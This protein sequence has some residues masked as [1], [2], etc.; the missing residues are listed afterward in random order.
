MA[1]VSNEGWKTTPDP[2]GQLARVR[3]LLAAGRPVHLE[4]ICR[5]A[6]GWLAASLVRQGIRPLLWICPDEQRAE[7]LAQEARFFLGEGEPH[8]TDPFAPRVAC[9]PLH[10]SSPYDDLSPDRSSEGERLALLLRLAE[11][12]PPDLLFAG[13]ASLL[14]RCLPRRELSATARLLLAGESI[15]L[16]ELVEHLLL[17]GYLRVPMVE[18]PGTFSVRGGIVDIF[19]PGLP[20]PLRLELLGDEIE[21]IRAFDPDSQRTV[22][23][24]DSLYL[25]PVRE[26][27]WDEA[28]RRQART[29]IERLGSERD[30]PSR[31]LLEPLRA[32]REGRW[33]F[34]IESLL[35]AFYEQ[36]GSLLDYL[37]A[38][39]SLVIDEGAEIEAGIRG[40]WERAE[41][42]WR[43]AAG[44]ESICFSPEHWLLP[45][46]SWRA[47]RQQARRL[48]VGLHEAGDRDT[49]LE[50][51]AHPTG[52][53]YQ[54]L[55]ATAA[56]AEPL[57][58][59]L[60]LLADWKR[61]GLRPVLVAGSAGRARELQQLFDLRHIKLQRLRDPG[62][63]PS[64]LA[65]G[66]G[67]EA[68][69]LVEGTLAEGFIVARPGGGT[70]YLPDSQIFGARRARRRERR[71]ARRPVALKPGD[72]VVHVDFGIG[73]FDK[74][75]RLEAGG[76][77]ADF[78]QL[79]FR[80]GDLLYLP[81]TRMGLL[82]R[83]RGPEG[84]P[85]PL[86]KLGGKA[87]ERA[88]ARV[89]RSLLEMAD[90]LVRLEAERQANPGQ[91]ASTPGED[92]HALA[93]SFPFEETEDQQRCIAEVVA[94]VTS[95]VVMDRLVCGDV[96]FGKTEVAVRAAYLHALDGRQTAVLV[97]TTILSLQHLATFR[98][99]L[100][101]Q[102][103]RVEMLNRLVPRA[104]QREILDDL[105][106]GR[107]DIVIGT[108]R[109]LQADVK[110]HELGLLVIDEEQRFGVRHK[111]RIKALRRNVDVLT[112]TATPLPRTLQL[113]LSGLRRISVIQTPPAGR[114]SIRTVISRFGRR[115]ISEAINSELSR[116]GQVFFLHNWVRSLPAMQHYL[117]R[118]VPAARLVVAH[119]QMSERELERAMAE[120]IERRADVMLCTSI[121]ES[122]LDIPSANTIIVNRA[123]LF[124]LAQLH[125]IR[126]RVGRASERAYAYLLVPGL[127]S[128]SR[129]ARQ[130]LEVLCQHNELGAGWRIAY[131]DMEMRGAGN[132]LGR[133]QSGHIAAVG[134]ALY[135]R[136]LE[137]A[138]AEVKGQAASETLDPELVLP[139]AGLLPEDY[140]PD[141]EQ[142]L[143]FYG[144]LS[145]A[146]DDEQVN[147]IEQELN[148]RFGPPPEEV[149]VL[150]EL[151]LLKVRLRRLRASRL[152][153]R[154][155]LLKLKLERQTTVTPQRLVQLAGREPQRVHLE[156]SGTV[157]IELTPG[158]VEQP[159]AAARHWLEA[160]IS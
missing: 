13:S 91:A 15:D 106:A 49:P 44:Q 114:R 120:F 59:L 33:F 61:R 138:V 103:L 139:V 5:P 144:R 116:G 127:E 72:Y 123:D 53:L 28:H 18:D 70:A 46:E 58:P 51:H 96:G 150:L 107:V 143:D 56:T 47:W 29:S 45:A 69:L 89:R 39:I 64:G 1:G 4:G 3:E 80:G 145:R 16:G 146:G 160:I 84:K 52:D 151:M 126:G 153:L 152:E 135:G 60:E 112:L 10:Q 159:L 128:I 98:A 38:G 137:R 131:E 9:L 66:R 83:Y 129:E 82:D 78:L 115:V 157:L 54:H 67:G 94:D 63:L 136:L 147:D 99:R 30:L 71:P 76:S 88:K 21:S 92:Y 109:L 2:A 104:R 108:H 50:L 48:G 148:D 35:P 149:E 6:R 22:R 118:I 8:P 42:A 156:P 79:S 97:P 140:V 40:Q 141:L 73:R 110:F 86:S 55:R 122:G 130:R 155:N 119:G 37:P 57:A 74:M 77:Q 95:P 23:R 117:Q 102:A 113:A 62:Q 14:R 41:A 81:V 32:L 43:E 36:L 26:I 27:L 90:E 20:L 11:G 134:F 75:R 100:E 85:P 124:G 101:E 17:L 7:Q 125:Q 121:I 65:P 133:D 12:T 154:R 87:W 31:R 68:V 19:T 142:R 25:G 105:A 111:E 132:L 24:S 34:G 93:A 158:E